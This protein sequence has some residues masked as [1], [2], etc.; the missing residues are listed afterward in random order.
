MTLARRAIEEGTTTGELVRRMI[1]K[2]PFTTAGELLS[3]I[4]AL[5]GDK[6]LAVRKRA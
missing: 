6:R 3:E 5:M 2:R 4:K 1:Q